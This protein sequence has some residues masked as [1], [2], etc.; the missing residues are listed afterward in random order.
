MRF[1]SNQLPR[2][3]AVWGPKRTLAAAAILLLGFAPSANAAARE[4]AR[5][6]RKAV[7]GRPNSHVKGYR[8]DRELTFRAA[9]GNGGSRTKVIVELKPGATLP[10]RYQQYAKRHGQLG[11]INGLAVELPN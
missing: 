10:S 2:Q 4:H 11:I 8:V 1:T 6:G 7:A 3:K 9:R 5:E